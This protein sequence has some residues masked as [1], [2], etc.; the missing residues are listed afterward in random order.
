VCRTLI[1]E[2][3]RNPI[4]GKNRMGTKGICILILIACICGCA[5]EEP[6]Q[7]K[8]SDS[9]VLEAGFGLWSW[10]PGGQAVVIEKT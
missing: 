5:K 4:K 1:Y 3:V 9:M 10:T 2:D 8:S 6:K 7:Q